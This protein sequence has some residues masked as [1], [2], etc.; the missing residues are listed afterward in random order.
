MIKEVSG[1]ESREEPRSEQFLKLY[2]ILEGLLERRYSGRHLSSPSVVMEYLRD[3]DSAPCRE[4]LDLCREIRN[5]LSHNADSA[6]EAIIE[7]SQSAVDLL[8]D[9]VDYVQ[10]PRLAVDC[11]TAGDRIMFAH[12]NDS[13]LDVIRHM[14]RMGYSHVPVRNKTGLVGVFSASSLMSFIGRAG[15]EGLNDALRIGDL[16][17]AL[18]VDDRYLF[19]DAAA[20]RTAVREAFEK[21]RDRNRRLAVIFITEDGT[22]D[23]PVLAIVTPWDVLKDIQ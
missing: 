1:L 21:H 6:G 16:K 10:R 2:R 7:P 18:N 4:D 17:E 19:M 23:T 9:I 11:G 3:A 12:P 14:L 13:A 20:T 5:L 8:R 22:R 15:L